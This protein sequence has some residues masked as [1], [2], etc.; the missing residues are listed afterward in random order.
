MD[1]FTQEV[2]IEIFSYMNEYEI[3]DLLIYIPEWDHEIHWIQEMIIQNQSLDDHTDKK[4]CQC[5][6]MMSP[7]MGQMIRIIELSRYELLEFY[8]KI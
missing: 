6:M 1:S 2:W 8:S 4:E 5:E 7:L 3:T